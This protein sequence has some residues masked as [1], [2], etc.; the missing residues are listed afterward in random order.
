MRAKH[1]RASPG[2]ARSDAPDQKKISKQPHHETMDLEIE[3]KYE[4]FESLTK[5]RPWNLKSYTKC[6]NRRPKSPKTYLRPRRRQKLQ[7][8]NIALESSTENHVAPG[9][10]GNIFAN[11]YDCTLEAV[12]NGFEKL[13]DN[14]R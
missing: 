11:E 1:F 8:V 10:H 14:K 3:E 5:S 9:T 13:P 6:T 2:K 7:K 4:G 12:S